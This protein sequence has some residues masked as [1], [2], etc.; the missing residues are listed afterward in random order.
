VKRRRLIWQLYPSF[1]LLIL[2]VLLAASWFVL[3]E[4]RS[5][6]FQ[7]TSRDLSAR[8]QLVKEQISDQLSE[9]YQVW[10]DQQVK[11]LGKNHDFSGVTSFHHCFHRISGSVH[12]ADGRHQAGGREQTI[13]CTMHH[14]CLI[15]C[16]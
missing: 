12:A 16:R 13:Q 7:Q 10:L 8:A 9:S 2:L 5:F 11:N 15:L 6:H 4:L 3:T 1:L 14:L